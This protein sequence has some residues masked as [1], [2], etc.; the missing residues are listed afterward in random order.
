[1]SFPLKPGKLVE[2]ITG[3]QWHPRDVN[4]AVSAR[5]ASLLAAGVRNENTVLILFG[6]N[7]EFFAELLAIWN[8]GGCAIPVDARLTAFEIQNIAKTSGAAFAIVDDSV[9][10]DILANLGN[11]EL[12]HTHRDAPDVP[13]ELP[14][15]NVDQPA[16][17]LFT[18][19]T[20]GQPKGVVHSH[21]T[22][23]AR[24]EALRENLGTHA[25]KRTLCLLPTHFGH[26][27][28]CNALYPWLSGCDL[29]IAPPFRPELVMRLGSLGLAGWASLRFGSHRDRA[30]WFAV[31]ALALRHWRY[32]APAGLL[33]LP[34]VCEALSRRLPHR[35]A[36]RP[37]WV[38]VPALFLAAALS[39]RQGP[40]PDRFPKA[41][42]EQL[43]ADAR[44]WSD[45]TLGA[46]LS[47]G[48]HPAFW[49]SRNDCYPPAVLEDGMRVAWQLDGWESVL[50][51]WEIDVVVTAQEALQTSLLSIGWTVQL[52]EGSVSALVPPVDS[53]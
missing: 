26:G 22:L 41:L 5:T 16:L 29:Y 7:L 34:I 33:L 51:H 53:E 38:L 31:T 27:L 32:C 24:W 48:G 19:G 1:M 35:P 4:A 46:W 43:P 8:V 30:L 12:L 11:V 39:P 25:F 10:T 37:G 15:V 18:S 14:I 20:T 3:R 52:R 2:P 9:D 23:S 44:V 45:F 50:Q 36:G 6:N 17:I 13:V 47:R 40:D 28:I 49:D 42:L 21:R